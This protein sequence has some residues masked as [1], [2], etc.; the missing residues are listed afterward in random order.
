[1]RTAASAC[2][3]AVVLATSA[4]AR[5]A[6]LL[7]PL[8]SQVYEA[9]GTAEQLAHRGETCMAQTLKPG[10]VNAPLI[11]SADYAGGTVVARNSFDYVD[12][13]F[14]RTDEEGRSR[15]TFEAKDGRFRISHTA[16]EQFAPG[17]GG[18]V[19]AKV[20]A[21]APLKSDLRARLVEISDMLAGCVRAAAGRS[22]W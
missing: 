3:L 11:V 4:A 8:T 17:L 9:A 13:G 22:E 14:I 10:L 15:V 16:I 12:R 21:D 7:E 19:A 18:W 2:L 20:W 6:V 1:M 5:E